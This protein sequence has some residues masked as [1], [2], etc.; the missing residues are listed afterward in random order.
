MSEWCRVRKIG[1]KYFPAFPDGFVIDMSCG[2]ADPA[3][4]Y[5]AAEEV[6]LGYKIEGKRNAFAP[7]EAVKALGLVSTSSLIARLEAEPRRT[8]PWHDVKGRRIRFAAL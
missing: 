1:K 6:E 2:Y 7:I 5:E 8:E 4:A 3:E